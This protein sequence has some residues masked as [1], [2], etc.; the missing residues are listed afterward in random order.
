MRRESDLKTIGLGT[1]I[2]TQDLRGTPIDIKTNPEKST[3]EIEEE[4]RVV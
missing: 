2:G 1:R 3:R 4:R